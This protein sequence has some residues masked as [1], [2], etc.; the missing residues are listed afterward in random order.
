MQISYS[1]NRFMHGVVLREI[2]KIRYLKISSLKIAIKP[3]YLSFDT[4]K[5]ILK[6]LD[7]DYPRKKDGKPFSYKELKEVDFLRHIAF[8]ECVCAENGYTL[9]LE[10]EYKDNLDNKQQ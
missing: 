6:Y 8:L 7:E 5:Q 3:F 2:K 1:F 9:N 4:L 10:K